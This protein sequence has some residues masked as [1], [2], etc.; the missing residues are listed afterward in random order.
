MGSAIAA[1]APALQAAAGAAYDSF[2][3]LRNSNS[4]GYNWHRLPTMKDND[5]DELSDQILDWASEH[6][7]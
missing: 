1:N 7:G 3:A 2:Q 5:S 6:K 4:P